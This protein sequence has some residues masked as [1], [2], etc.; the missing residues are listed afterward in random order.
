M[1]VREVSECVEGDLRGTQ[2]GGGMTGRLLQG[3]CLLLLMFAGDVCTTT[4]ESEMHGT[5][6]STWARVVWCGG[7][8]VCE[9]NCR[10]EIIAAGVERE[11]ENNKQRWA[12]SSE[13]VLVALAVLLE[14][15][16]GRHCFSFS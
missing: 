7:V 4:R 2:G 5:G 6:E 14:G 9:L 1:S 12:I 11:H 13:F 8:E 10:I 15:P 3:S 16:E